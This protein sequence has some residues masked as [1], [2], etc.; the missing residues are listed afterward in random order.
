MFFIYTIMFILTIIAIKKNG[1]LFSPLSIVF[2][3]WTFSLSIF[4]SGLIQYTSINFQGYLL[5][6]N[7]LFSFLIIDKFYSIKFYR[8]SIIQ[9]ADHIQKLNKNRLRGSIYFL[10]IIT[11]VSN[12][13][14]ILYFS[15]R[16]GFSLESFLMF[17]RENFGIPLLGS[18]SYLSALVI[19]LSFIYLSVYKRKK[20]IM[21]TIIVLSSFFLS[22]SVQKTNLIRAYLWAV[23]S[24]SF[25][26]N[27]KLNFK[28][29]IIASI[30][31]VTVF[32]IYNLLN[33]SYYGLDYRFWVRDGIVKLPRYLS[34]ISL[35]LVYISGS[36]SA[37]S[38]LV[39]DNTTQ[40]FYGLHT[41][42][43]L[44]S[45]VFRFTEYSDL[46]VDT[47][48][49]FYDI[50]PMPY[51]VY[52]F[53][54]HAYMDFGFIGAIIY[55]YLIALMLT[56]TYYRIIYRGSSHLILLYGIFAWGLFI[57]TF[58]NHFSYSYMWMYFI[59]AYIFGRYIRGK[60]E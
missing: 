13:I 16:F 47:H 27:I 23:V 49:K 52:T 25:F 55:P 45:L 8:Y 19:V 10:F 17:G 44:V 15:A 20:F 43:P 39:N 2:L 12:F 1:K 36:F 40:L 26:K 14:Q 42:K 21:F 3:I 29:I 31:V 51:N 24:F 37:L 18:I 6:T 54:R 30:F 53:L 46:I 41:F 58:S 60:I 35:P 38:Q 59:F 28:N 5:I 57:S 32:T 48:G 56:S 4:H 7:V 33:S 9:K 11:S 22:M 34:F 50:G